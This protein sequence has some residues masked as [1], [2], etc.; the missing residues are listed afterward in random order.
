MVL[1]FLILSRNGA[2]ERLSFRVLEQR[3][4]AGHWSVIF[5]IVV[6]VVVVINIVVVVAVDVFVVI[7]WRVVRALVTRYRV[8]NVVVIVV[9]DGSIVSCCRRCRCLGDQW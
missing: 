1:V 7:I 4:L 9:V 8:V 2:V 3:V 5:A 6:A